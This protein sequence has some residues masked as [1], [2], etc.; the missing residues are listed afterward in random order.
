MEFIHSP[1]IWTTLPSAEV[2]AG[3]RGGRRQRGRDDNYV[4]G[5]KKLRGGCTLM[6]N[7]ENT[8]SA[9][10]NTTHYYHMMVH[11]RL[12][13]DEGV[14]AMS[15]DWL[16]EGGAGSL[17]QQNQKNHQNDTRTTSQGW[18]NKTKSKDR[19]LCFCWSLC[20]HTWHPLPPSRLGIQVPSHSP[21][22][23]QEKWM[24]PAR[25]HSWL[26]SLPHSH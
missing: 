21:L 2:C 20:Q 16:L 26:R 11:L 8:S 17:L 9:F 13:A 25:V 7:N 3:V 5:E 12:L 14:E 15:P 6:N 4:F 10:M 22:P 19:C 18:W 23:L 1:P 24:A